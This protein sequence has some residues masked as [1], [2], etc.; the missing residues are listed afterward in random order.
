MR[1]CML[2]SDRSASTLRCALCLFPAKACFDHVA[3][4]VPGL[5]TKGRGISARNL[6]PP[7]SWQLEPST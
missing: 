1:L 4:E 6:S 2:R 5:L 3:C 7:F